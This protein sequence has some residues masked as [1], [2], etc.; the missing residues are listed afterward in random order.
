M[1]RPLPPR[2]GTRVTL[3]MG[4]LLSF[5]SGA[6]LALSE[7]RRFN[8]FAIDNW[9]VADGLPQVAVQSLAQDGDGYVWVG[10]Q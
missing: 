3:L 8:D 1:E 7:S 2:R 4:V 5:C 9:T 6:A 10:T